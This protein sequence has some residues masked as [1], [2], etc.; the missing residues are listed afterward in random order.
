MRSPGYGKI[1]LGEHIFPITDIHLRPGG[2][3][4]V[5]PIIGPVEPFGPVQAKTFDSKGR[6]IWEG[7]Q[8]RLSKAIKPGAL[9]EVEY[10][11]DIQLDSP[12]EP[13]DLAR[14]DGHA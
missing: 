2:I 1:Q 5:F 11:V 12:P 4:L 8:F 10:R 6:L 9:W 13:Q 7:R 14:E 3:T